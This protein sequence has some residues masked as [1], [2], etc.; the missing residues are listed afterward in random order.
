MSGLAKRYGWDKELQP[1]SVTFQ[2]GEIDCMTC[3]R[4]I[5][6]IKNHP[7]VESEI[8]NK[9]EK[10]IDD[11]DKGYIELI[12]EIA[13]FFPQTPIKDFLEMRRKTF[14]DFVHLAIKDANGTISDIERVT[15]MNNPYFK[16][17]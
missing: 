9:Q 12:N 11:L 4:R 8:I 5:A 10:F 15:L 16:K 14:A 13:D 17:L 3:G 1:S 7:Y 6:Y 2:T